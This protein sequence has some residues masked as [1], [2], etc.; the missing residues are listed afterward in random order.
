[1]CSCLRGRCVCSLLGAVGLV[2]KSS[3]RPK[4]AYLLVRRFVC[5]ESFAG[6]VIAFLSVV[7]A[8]IVPNSPSSSLVS[9]SVHH[10]SPHPSPPFHPD[11]TAANATGALPHFCSCPFSASLRDK[12]T[13]P[14]GLVFPAS[15]S[16]SSA[17]ASRSKLPWLP[18]DGPA[19]ALETTGNSMLTALA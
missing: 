16:G 17:S 3:T 14:E 18:P 11:L 7:I 10:V 2:A 5:F 12:L 9:R 19:P 15:L 8:L 6:L 4:L 1:M 13:C